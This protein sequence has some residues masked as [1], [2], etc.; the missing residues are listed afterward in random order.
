MHAAAVR[1]KGGCI[2]S[3]WWRGYLVVASNQGNHVVVE[4]SRAKHMAMERGKGACG[5]G[6]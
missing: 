2:G 6:N 4:S 1:Q 5:D 3:E